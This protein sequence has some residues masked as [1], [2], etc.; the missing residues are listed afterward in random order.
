M[1]KKLTILLLISMVV[2]IIIGGPFLSATGS[3]VTILGYEDQ[4]IETAKSMLTIPNAQDIRGNITLPTKLNVNGNIVNISWTSDK[5]HVINTNEIQNPNYYS[6]PPGVVTRQATDTN[7]TLTAFLSYGMSTGTVNIKVKVKAKPAPVKESDYKGYLFTHFSGVN[8][9]DAEQIYFAASE[10]GLFWTELNKN[11]PV[12]VSNVGDKGV[13]DPYIIRSPEG[14]KF[15]MVATDLRIANG[16]GWTAAQ[17]SGS[18]CV[19]V[20]ES[21]DLVNW[22]RERLVKVARDDAGCTWAPE[23]VYDDITGEYV[24]FWASRVAQDNYAKQRIYMAKTRD[25][26]T[27]TEPV[28]WIEKSHDVIDTTVIKHNGMYYRFSKNESNKTIFI[29]KASQI[30][31]NNYQQVFSQSVG[32]ISGVEGPAVFKFNGENKWCLLLDDY[33]GSGYFPMVTNDLSSGEFTKLSSSQYSLPSAP[34][35]GTVIQITQSEYDAVMEKWA[36]RQKPQKDPVLEY[37]FDERLSGRTIADTSGNNN[38]GTL[39]GNA[40]YVNDREKNSQV[41]Y[42]DGTQGTFAAFPQ[43]F[44]DGMSTM[45]VSMD[46]KPVTVSGNFFTFTIGK[47]NVKYMFLRTRDT[48]IRNAIT[49][50]SYGSEQDAKITTAPIANKW[51]NI[52]LVITPRTMAIYKDGYLLGKNNNVSISVSNLGSELLA[53]LGKSFYS[54]DLYFKGYFD[55][56]K[57]YNRALSQEEIEKEFGIKNEAIKIIS[58]EDVV[59]TGKPGEEIKLPLRVNVKYS[60]GTSGTARVAWDSFD[61]KELLNSGSITVE[62]TLY[63]NEY[64]NPL[65]LNRADPFIYR[66]TDGYYYFTASYTDSSSGRNNVGMYQYD[67]IVIRRAKTIEGLS[68]AEEKVIYTKAPLEGNKSPHVWAPEIHF[69][70]GDWYIYYA[71]TVSNTDVW[72]I[73]PHVLKCSGNLDPMVKSN[74]QDLGQMRK[75]NSSDM[76]FKG[77]SLDATV[78]EH[79]GVRYLVWA[80][81]D[82]YSNLYIARMTDPLTIDNAVKIAE[83][84]YDW[85]KQGHQVNEGAAVIKRNGKIFIAYS[86]SATDASYCVGLLTADENSNLLS[87]GSW[88]KKPEPI[89]WSNASTGQYGPGHNCFTV[90]EDGVDDII[91]YHARKEER[92]INNNYEPLYDVGRHTRVQK[93]FWN[94]DGTP[95]FGIPAPDGKVASQV[96]VKAKIINENPVNIKGDINGDG[97]VDSIDCAMLKRHLLE[98]TQLSEDVLLNADVTGDGVIDSRDYTLMTRFVLEIISSF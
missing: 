92:Y 57:V 83:P 41:L 68:S 18:K 50:N 42:L 62:G 64:D 82:P 27:F 14:D 73:R 90:S 11:N 15:Y 63:D 69:I 10:D 54:A 67:R 46:I 44:F 21:Y 32:S 75:V 66:H 96:K 60:N 38:T 86:A 7:V 95:Y 51:M 55:N 29:E 8:R 33:G 91:V 94:S 31:S 23:I 37:K 77:F 45:T 36:G 59:I 30:L 61:D 28:L 9:Q 6:T 39:N 70:D 40:T 72:Q 43:G 22:S 85:E 1:K 76:A 4:V 47:D 88:V 93:L 3:G 58:A 2:G 49:L 20:W 52:K 56:V 26:Y 5:P 34:R 12:L 89:M 65:I 81:N 97:K 74:W 79:K 98:I 17:R 13:R 84:V 53:Y 87:P 16:A 71:T 19:V 25:F 78:F 24:L 48:E 35:H 80:Q